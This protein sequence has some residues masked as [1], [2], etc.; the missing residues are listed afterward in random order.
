MHALFSGFSREFIASVAEGLLVTLYVNY[1]SKLDFM[2]QFRMN[3]EKAN[4]FLD[5]IETTMKMYGRV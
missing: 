5:M 4:Q 3:K 1:D 2:E